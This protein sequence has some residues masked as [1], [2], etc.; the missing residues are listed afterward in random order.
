MAM[1]VFVHVHIHG[2]AGQINRF[3]EYSAYTYG[4]LCILT[5]LQHFK[6]IDE[7]LINSFIII[8]ILAFYPDKYTQISFYFHPPLPLLLSL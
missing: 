7:N 4:V 2:K 6:W 3:T 8:S 5:A 1:N